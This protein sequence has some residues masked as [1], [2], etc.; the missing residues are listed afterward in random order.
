MVVNM[1]YPIEEKRAANI[2]RLGS[3][4]FDVLIVGGGINGAGIARDL[5]LRGA[6]LKVALIEKNHFASGTSGRNS[7]LIH[8]GLR[9]LKY[10]EFELVHEAQ[11]ERKTLM[12]IAPHLVRQ[13][14]FLIPVLPPLR[15]LVLRGRSRGLRYPRRARLDRLF[16][17]KN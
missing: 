2:E 16:P 15:P 11:T 13:I 12:K 1:K 7:Q 10:L 3:E 14:Q 9:Y 17:L 5:T 6:G 8:G 4:E